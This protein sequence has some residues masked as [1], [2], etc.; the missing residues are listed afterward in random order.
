MMESGGF[1]P[2]L[3]SGHHHGWSS[4]AS[5]Q[6]STGGRFHRTQ[7]RGSYKQMH[8]TRENWFLEEPRVMADV[9]RGGLESPTALGAHQSW[10]SMTQPQSS[11]STSSPAHG[12]FTL[13]SNL[14]GNQ[15]PYLPRSLSSSL[16]VPSP[17]PPSTSLSASPAESS[18]ADPLPPAL[19]GE[20]RGRGGEGEGEEGG[21]KDGLNWQSRPLWQDGWGAQG[22]VCSVPRL[23]EHP[24]TSRRPLELSNLPS[25]LDHPKD[26]RGHNPVLH[27]CDLKQHIRDVKHISIMSGTNFAPS[28]LPPLPEHF[29]SSEVR[30]TPHTAHLTPEVNPPSVLNLD[31]K[32][33]ALLLRKSTA[34]ICCHAGYH[35]AS[36]RALDTLAGV[37]GEFLSRLCKQ[38]SIHSER[39]GNSGHDDFRANIQ[40]PLERCLWSCGIQGRAELHSFWRTEVED[41]M[42]RLQKTAAQLHEDPSPSS[43]PP[44]P[45]PPPRPLS[46]S[47]WPPDLGGEKVDEEISLEDTLAT[48]MSI[49]A[50]ATTPD[51][52]SLQTFLPDLAGQEPEGFVLLTPDL[53]PRK[54]LRTGSSFTE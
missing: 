23:L 19:W 39:Q 5:T 35:S 43:L 13:A 29:G 30:K 22:L 33:V 44:P 11:H 10:F 52:G 26:R 32:S 45:L 6:S 15:Q 40:D 54:R 28:D 2:S 53:A 9:P 46:L 14:S 24:P 1:Q 50:P 34:T 3:G 12:G 21:G 7:N 37:M 8:E 47:S 42:R 51:P 16:L 20:V 18:S 38:L 36:L 25:L 27:S 48:D 41:G 49:I 31:P 17:L 4:P